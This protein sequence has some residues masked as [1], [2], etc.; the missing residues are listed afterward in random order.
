VPTVEVNEMP[1]MSP[2]ALQIIRDALERF[3]AGSEEL[4]VSEEA[5]EL[6]FAMT[7]STGLS[8][9]D[10]LIA[11]A[12]GLNMELSWDQLSMIWE[13]AI[14]YEV[15][16]DKSG[17]YIGWLASSLE[18][19]MT[20]ESQTSQTERQRIASD[21]KGILD[22]AL[23]GSPH[24]AGIANLFGLFYFRH[25]SATLDA[26]LI[27]KSLHWFR[28]SV[29]WSREDGDDIDAFTR[30]HIGH[31]LFALHRW[32]EALAEYRLV[33]V[34][35]LRHEVGDEAVAEMQLRMEACLRNQ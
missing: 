25:P 13:R 33:D 29:D 28:T 7:E 14:D 17:I 35:Q 2:A 27:E 6:Y 22:R 32:S 11:F 15:E 18:W 20:E 3:R 19:W 23:E 24:N 8:K 1:G 34:E 9:T 10:R 4:V 12:T 5:I 31:C 26:S 30:L 16:T 21:T